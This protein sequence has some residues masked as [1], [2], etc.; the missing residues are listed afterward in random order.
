MRKNAMNMFRKSLFCIENHKKY[1]SVKKYQLYKERKKE[2]LNQ[3]KAQE[4]AEEDYKKILKF[5]EQ[6]AKDEKEDNLN[7]YRKIEG[8]SI[9]YGQ[10]IQLKHIYSGCYLTLKSEDLARQN[11]CVEV[12]LII[13]NMF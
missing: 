6:K 5:W 7:E 8:Q 9:V 13:L 4:F 10:S 3:K 2:L 1:L 11:G 12:L